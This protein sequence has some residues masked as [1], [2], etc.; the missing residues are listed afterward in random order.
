MQTILNFLIPSGS[1]QAATSMPIMAPL[2]DLLGLQRDVAPSP[3]RKVAER[4]EVG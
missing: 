1:G 3:L 4:S 2:A